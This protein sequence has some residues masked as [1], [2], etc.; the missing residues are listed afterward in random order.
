MER[1][2]GSVERAVR[3]VAGAGTLATGLLAGRLSWWGILLDA[4]G[5][6]L[7][8]SAATAFC[9]VK[10]TLGICPAPREGGDPGHR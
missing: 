5:A 4:V 8:L 6:L 9:H 3:W 10:K 7:L 2:M 1:N